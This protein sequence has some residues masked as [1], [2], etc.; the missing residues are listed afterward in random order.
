M[1]NLIKSKFQTLLFVNSLYDLASRRGVLHYDQQIPKQQLS[2]VCRLALQNT[3]PPHPP[4]QQDCV[5]SDTVSHVLQA[6]YA[7]FVVLILF[8]CLFIYLLLLK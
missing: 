1:K 5:P 4:P 6:V 8:I 7:T 3:S 2:K